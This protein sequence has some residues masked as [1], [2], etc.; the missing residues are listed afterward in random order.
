M[1]ARAKTLSPMSAR[2]KT[3]SPMSARAK[4]LTRWLLPDYCSLP[5]T[6]LLA[7]RRQRTLGAQPGGVLGQRL[8]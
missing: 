3:L 2:A 1:S 4:T 5:P 7:R 6:A 8:D